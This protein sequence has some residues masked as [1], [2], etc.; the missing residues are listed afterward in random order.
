MPTAIE[1]Q[2]MSNKNK[3]P[4]SDENLEANQFL[5]KIYRITEL[6]WNRSTFSV[7]R[8]IWSHFASNYKLKNHD[9]THL[10]KEEL[11]TAIKNRDLQ[12][13]DSFC[14]EDED[15]PLWKYTKINSGHYLEKN[16]FEHLEKL[17]QLTDASHY[18]EKIKHYA[19]KDH[20][21][22]QLLYAF[23]CLKR[24]DQ[25][26]AKA[27]LKRAAEKYDLAKFILLRNQLFKSKQW[28]FDTEQTDITQLIDGIENL[29]NKD[30]IYKLLGA[31]LIHQTL[32]LK[33]SGV[34]FEQLSSTLQNCVKPLLSY[35]ASENKQQMILPYGGPSGG[36]FPLY[37]ILNAN[38]QQQNNNQH[39]YKNKFSR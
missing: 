32:C 7:C 8:K 33:N 15:I 31:G 25:H 11:D 27:Y 39:S 30:K 13:P 16:I 12:L 35:H 26:S 36:I 19:D 34:R 20:S 3:M 38:K 6:N 18:E 23:I 21:R 37:R 2:E 10:T 4:T 9:I 1:M 5:L 14:Q 17:N 24:N 29:S 28:G 22:F